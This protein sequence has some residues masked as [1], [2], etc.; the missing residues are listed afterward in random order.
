MIKVGDII[1]IWKVNKILFSNLN[2]VIIC[3]VSTYKIDISEL[4]NKLNGVSNWVMKL[5]IYEKDYSEVDIIKKIN[6]KDVPNSVIPNVDNEY[7]FGIYDK[8]EWYIIEKCDGDINKYIQICDEKWD[9]LLEDVC[10][11]LKYLHH[12]KKVVHGDL[13]TTNILYNSELNK[14][15][16]CDYESC[17]KPVLDLLCNGITRN[18][19]LSPLKNSYLYNVGYYYYYIGA[20]LNESYMSYKMDLL[21]LGVI[22]WN[23]C[24][25]KSKN[26]TLFK[27]QT[28]A[29]ELYESNE[30]YNKF[31]E[32]E[33]LKKA[34]EMPEMIKEYF[35]IVNTI[36][37]LSLDPP[38][39]NIY[40]KIL[41]LK[42]YKL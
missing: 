16:V 11:F 20:N 25:Y 3:D 5:R 6:F 40:N 18:S 4:L 13:K 19:K 24:S 41:S 14:F 15:K 42:K 36:D 22:L 34:E 33:Q 32:L 12:V 31:S 2:N 39:C 21:S 29:I 1:G 23:I 26:T 35:D 27:W 28:K 37:P 38:D 9:I 8:Y 7:I 30:K 10:S 17:Q